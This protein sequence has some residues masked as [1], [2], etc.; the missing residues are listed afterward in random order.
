MRRTLAVLILLLLP[1][2]A[3]AQVKVRG[4]ANYPPF[5]KI[6]LKA[7]DVT[8]KSAQF[9]WDVDGAADVVEAGDTLYVWAPPGT[10]AV[11]LTAVDFDAKKV[12]RARFGFTVGT[13]VPPLP[14]VP[15]DPGPK[16]PQPVAAL[17]VLI[18][19]DSSAEAAMPKAQQLVLRTAPVRDWLNAHC[20]ASEETMSK[21][22]WFIVDK[23]EDVTGLHPTWKS[24]MGR[25]RAGVPWIVI[26]SDA[27]VAYEGPLPA[28]TGATIALLSKYAAQSQKRRAA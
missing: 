1:L 11:R 18:I 12:E 9:L 13:P 23:G 24:W 21:R 7:G 16:P 28:D 27:G 3:A 26:G 17:K 20:T 19:Y 6:V 2:T 14:P 25:T 15:P 4:E 22:A 5:K 8:S 10:Y